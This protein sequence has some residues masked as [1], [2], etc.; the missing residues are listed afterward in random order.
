MRRNSAT[1]PARQLP[2]P[3]AANA[4]AAQF[5]NSPLIS[6]ISAEVRARRNADLDQRREEDNATPVNHTQ[7]TGEQLSPC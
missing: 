2:H 6:K 3:L 4:T 1:G 7:S 5:S